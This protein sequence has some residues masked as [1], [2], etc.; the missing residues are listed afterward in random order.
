VEDADNF[1]PRDVKPAP[2]DQ[3]DGEDEEE[4]DT[5]DVSFSLK[6]LGNKM[7]FVSGC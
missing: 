1:E 3:W 2:K 5:A 6:F 4:E 7:Q